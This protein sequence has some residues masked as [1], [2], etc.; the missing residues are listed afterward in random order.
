MGKGRRLNPASPGG[1]ERTCYDFGTL[2]PQGRCSEATT[3]FGVVLLSYLRECRRHEVERWL[4]LGTAASQWAELRHALPDPD[5][6]QHIELFYDLDQK[7]AEGRVTQEDLDHWQSHLNAYANRLEFRLVLS[8]DAMST[9]SQ[10]NICR[11]LFEHVPHE[12]EVAFDVSHGFRHQPLLAAFAVQM[13]RWTHR[14]RHVDFYSG[15]LEARSGDGQ[16]APVLRLDA[17][18]QLL[19]RTEDAAVLELTGNYVPLAE[20][21]GLQADRMRFLEST[22]QITMVRKHQSQ[23][24]SELDERKKRYDPVD[25]LCADLLG[26]AWASSLRLSTHVE[27]AIA[28]VS[29]TLNS[30]DYLLA[31]T[32]AYEAMVWQVV[33]NTPW[34]KKDPLE[35]DEADRRELIKRL[36]SCCGGK[37][38]QLYNLLREVRNACVHG[39][40]PAS[41]SAQQAMSDPAQFRTLIE[42][43]LQM[44]DRLPNLLASVTKP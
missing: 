13:M 22:N 32:L 3:L 14:L 11:A 16:A 29:Q 23:L 9:A 6:D 38:V 35:F 44:I 42:R 8:G 15:V 41:K 19:R 30:G 7:V 17:C 24:I 2:D 31:V 4:V 37:D 34:L 40:R 27:R 43:S 10:H 21:L 18:Q 5:A 20:D 25:A 36:R 33:R 12:S 26:N 1:Y 28:R 39:T